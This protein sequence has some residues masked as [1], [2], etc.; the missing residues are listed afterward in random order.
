MADDTDARLVA[1]LDADINKLIAK[2]SSANQAVYGSAA[3]IHYNLRRSACEDRCAASMEHRFRSGR[4]G[5]HREYY[6]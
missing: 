3:K 4:H 2:L 6:D 1:V 5:D